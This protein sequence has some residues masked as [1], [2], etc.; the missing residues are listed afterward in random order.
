VN[1]AFLAIALLAALA[2]IAASDCE[3][4]R[5][6]SAERTIEIAYS[7]FEPP[8]VTVPAG[9]PVT[10]V[11]R[12]DDPIEHEWIVG[13]D[14]VHARHRTGTEPYHDKVATEVTLPAFSER[15]TTVTFEEAGEYHYICHLPGHEGYGMTGVVRVVGD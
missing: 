7:K 8:F 1:P 12:N 11:L 14:D 3:R 2:S 15:T 4:A 10:F 6:P 5:P 13:T 9:V